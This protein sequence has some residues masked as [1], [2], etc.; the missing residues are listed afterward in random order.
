[1]KGEFMNRKQ[2]GMGFKILYL[3]ITLPIRYYRSLKLIRE[4]VTNIREAS[5]AMEHSFKTIN[6]KL[7]FKRSVETITELSSFHRRIERALTFL[8][9]VGL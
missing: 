5:V 4:C 9:N 3:K 8:K 6:T 1:M 2:I 7:S